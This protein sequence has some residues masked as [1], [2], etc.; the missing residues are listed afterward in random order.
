MGGHSPPMTGEVEGR[1]ER[2]ITTYMYMAIACIL[3]LRIDFFP[4]VKTMMGL[5]GSKMK[6]I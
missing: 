3:T 6:L 2:A 1:R 4:S 5:Q